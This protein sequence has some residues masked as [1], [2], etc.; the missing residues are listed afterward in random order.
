MAIILKDAEVFTDGSFLRRDITIDGNEDREFELEGFCV[1]LGLVD[2]HVHLREPGFP[3]KETIKTGSEAAA[4]SGYS[5]IFAMPN[6]KPVPDSREHLK[7]ELDIIERDAYINVLPFGSITA[8]EKG[9]TLSDMSGMNESVIGFSDDGRGVQ[10][11][12]VM[13]DAMELCAS[14]DSIIAA[15]CEDESL[16]TGGYVHDGEY[17]KENGLPGISSESEWRMIERDL[18]LA[19]ETG[20]RYHVCHISTKESVTLIRD[21]KRSGVDVSCET[22]PHYLVFADE[23]IRDDGRFKMNPPIRSASDREALIEG[24]TDGTVDMIATD[25]APHSAKEKSG[26]LKG[27]FNGIVGLETAF[28]V[29]YTTLVRRGVITLGKLTELMSINARRR[30]RIKESEADG[31]GKDAA[32]FDLSSGYNID[33]ERFRSMGRST[34]FEGMYVFGSCVM[35]IT[36]GRLVYIDSSIV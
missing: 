25:H 26:G 17:A 6:L 10:D 16:L 28:P 24:I 14:L 22:A 33:T 21:A 3:Y 4:V 29:L 19:D 34:P 23:D 27:S 31:F 15:H 7:E 35:N 5:H 12:A 32:V 18:K 13:K 11:P 2:P 1:L 9:N 30:F 8:A 20:C 36:G